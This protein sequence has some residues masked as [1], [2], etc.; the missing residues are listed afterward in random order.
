MGVTLL[1]EGANSMGFR[2]YV[3]FWGFLMDLK[4]VQEG[5]R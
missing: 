4:N 5:W 2:D 1:N 3:C